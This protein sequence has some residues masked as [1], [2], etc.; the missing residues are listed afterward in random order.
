MLR[1]KAVNFSWPVCGRTRDRFFGIARLDQVFHHF[2]STGCGAGRELSAE[3]DD[4][5][6]FIGGTGFC[7]SQNITHVAKFTMNACHSEVAAATKLRPPNP[8][9][10]PIPVERS[11]GVLRQ[12][13]DDILAAGKLSPAFARPTN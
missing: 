9:T 3:N 2:P 1:L 4:Q 10:R 13:R 12:P 8:W 11:H 6:C 7:T 5:I